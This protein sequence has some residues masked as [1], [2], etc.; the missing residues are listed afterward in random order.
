MAPSSCAAKHLP[1]V[2]VL[3]RTLPL[4][5]I[6]FFEALRPH[7]ELRGVRFRIIYGQPASEEESRRDTGEIDW[8][9]SIRNVDFCLGSRRVYW[10]PCLSLLKDTDLVIVEQA[11]KLLINY[12]LILK[13]HVGGPKLAF[14]GHG[15]NLM[16]HR[17]S[18][19]GE[20]IKRI[21]S[22]R[23]H[24]WFAYNDSSAAMVENMGFPQ[25]RITVV[26]NT[27]E[28]KSLLAR[29]DATTPSDLEKLRRTVGLKGNN[30]AVFLGGLYAEKRIDFLLQAAR[31]I[32]SR[33][34]DFE[35]LVVGA[36]SQEATVRQAALAAPW[37]HFI[38]PKFHGDR[39]PYLMLSKVMLLPGAV[40]LGIIDSF[41][42]E[43]PL[44][45]VDRSAHGPEIEYLEHRTN[46]LKLDAET[47][48]EQYGQAVVSILEDERHLSSLKKG[49]R[50]SAGQYRLETMVE[51]FAEGV[52][53]ALE[54]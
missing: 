22:P 24:W 35:L 21:V 19:I 28:T 46:G 25:E 9:D 29:K 41:A 52:L 1:V 42:L 54:T 2:T 4:Y 12:F 37:I 14:W 47:T 51:R 45:T 5:R 3:Y 17:A 13:Q 34:P 43:V 27:I 38:G 44:I 18:A 26:Q 6:P 15:K 53:K 49:C 36:G 7:L 30:V 11:S 31:S 32:R 23:A 50:N 40:G 16:A 33:I 48:A 20:R 8:G 10:Q 39:V